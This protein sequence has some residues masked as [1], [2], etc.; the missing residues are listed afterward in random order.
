MLI[1]DGNKTVVLCAK[2]GT[3]ASVGRANRFWRLP[4]AA[5]RTGPKVGAIKAAQKGGAK[6]MVQKR[7]C[8]R[9]GA[10]RRGQIGGVEGGGTKPVKE[11]GE[12]GCGRCEATPGT[13]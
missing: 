6:N 7:W 3:L 8:K 12:S 10:N 4:V 5:K 13:G 1:S 11:D 2:V 9:D